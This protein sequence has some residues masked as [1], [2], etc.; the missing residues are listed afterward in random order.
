MERSTS[1]VT[2]VSSFSEHLVLYDCS[3]CV[4][5]FLMSVCGSPSFLPI[6]IPNSTQLQL[7]KVNPPPTL[8]ELLALGNQ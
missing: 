3:E 1:T 7:L 6:L 5:V 2:V 4:N 8:Q